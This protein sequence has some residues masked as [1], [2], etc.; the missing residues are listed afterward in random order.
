MENQTTF[1]EIVADAER[2]NSTIGEV[3]LQ[4]ETELLGLHRDQVLGRMRERWLVMTRSVENGLEKENRSL[5][6][7]VGGEG[8]YL[9]GYLAGG[10]TLSGE[11]TLLAAARALGVAG[12]NAS[13][14][15]V[16]A[17]PTAGSCGILPAVL[18]TVGEKVGAGEK[19]IVLALFAAAGIG[20][21]IDE[22]ATTSG[23]KGGCQAECGSAS[24]MAAVAA[25][26]LAGG[27]PRQAAHAAAIALK[28]IL[29]MV[30]DPV[31]GLVE[32]PCVK[33][34]AM[35]AANALLA[36][37]MALAGIESRIPVDEVIQAMREIGEQM[38]VSLKETAQGGLAATPTAREIAAR[39]R[40]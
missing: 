1:E 8:A 13:M 26:E 4:Q 36:A 39:L 21:I 10:K 25:V 11:T 34:N 31:A 24:S 18:M 5:S 29:G 9:A 22:N 2:R 27:T 12:L 20:R 40:G 37:D 16:V 32:I 19:Q 28:A 33:R 14:G 15:R 17:C 23:A 6:G 30:C 7:L 38:P 3:I 35:G